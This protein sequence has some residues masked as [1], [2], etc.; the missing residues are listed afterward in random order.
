MKER[1]KRKSEESSANE[2]DYLHPEECDREKK[3][4]LDQT[5]KAVQEKVDEFLDDENASKES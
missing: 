4:N 5:K 1:D 3:D 2:C